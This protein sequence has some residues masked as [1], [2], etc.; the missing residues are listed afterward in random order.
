MFARAL[1]WRED[2]QAFYD[3]DPSYA[4][5]Y[6]RRWCYGAKRSRLQP[7]KAFVALVEQNW[8]S[9]IAAHTTNH[10]NG[11]PEGTQ[12]TAQAGNAAANEHHP[13]GIAAHVYA[14]IVRKLRIEADQLPDEPAKS[15]R[16]ENGEGDTHPDGKEH[17]CTELRRAGQAWH[18]RNLGG[19]GRIVAWAGFRDRPCRMVSW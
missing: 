16:I 1:R 6:L 15:G 10:R 19:S 4:P 13:Q 12:P 3:Q 8:D 17:P 9:H 11:H 2:F 7:I 18:E 5:A 14:A